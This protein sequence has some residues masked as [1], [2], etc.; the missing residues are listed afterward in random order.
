LQYY[1]SGWHIKPKGVKKPWVQNRY[2][3]IYFLSNIVNICSY[4]PILGEFFR[5]R[6]DYTDGT[7]GFYISEQGSSS[8]ALMYRVIYK[9]RSISPSSHFRLLLYLSRK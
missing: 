2:I 1:L 7:Q 9:L 8:E 6:Y 4:N 3:L 5:C